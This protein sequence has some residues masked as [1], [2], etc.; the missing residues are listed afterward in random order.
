MSYV[1]YHKES[2]LRLD[3]LHSA[4]KLALFPTVKGARS[5]LTRACNKDITLIK[6][7]FEIIDAVHFYTEIEKKKIVKNLMTGKD[8]EQTVNTPHCLDVSSEAY[9][10]A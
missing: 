10:S 2:T 5:A 3:R 4:C 6:E 7:S 1:V 8:V 9:W